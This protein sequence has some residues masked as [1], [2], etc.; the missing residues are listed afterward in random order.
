MVKI[1]RY[2]MSDNKST[3][4]KFGAGKVLLSIAAGLILGAGILAGLYFW[5]S[6][7][8]K[9]AAL[10]ESSSMDAATVTLYSAE[11]AQVEKTAPTVEEVSDE[12]IETKDYGYDY[13]DILYEEEGFLL[14]SI[15]GKRYV[16]YIA[17]IDDPNRV[18]LGTSGYFSASV[19]GKSVDEISNA[20]N[21]MLAVNGGGFA[22]AQGVGIGGLPTGVVI[23][24]GVL[25]CSARAHSVGIDYD[26]KLH[27]GYY[28]G[29][30]MMAMN[31]RW[32][33]SYGPTLIDDGEVLTSTNINEEPRTAIGQREDGSI[34]ILS[35]QGRQVA[36][37]GVTQTELAQIMADY[38]AIEA[39]NLDG[40]ASSD[41]YFKGEFVNTAN[42]SG[43][44]RPIPTAVLVSYADA[45]E[46]SE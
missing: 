34:I 20:N 24:D 19:A 17:V 8:E 23:E 36:A 40:G 25:R 43:E 21:A 39:S 14:A 18:F 26:G 22:D 27:A 44:P 12:L 42:S 37:L 30:E 31:M 4:T 35:I 1:R 3:P 28:N 10:L 45:E 41:M 9:P 13:K 7:Q 46:V 6:N 11:P 38:G 15:Q 2:F 16:G 32:A 5:G 29:D 33:I